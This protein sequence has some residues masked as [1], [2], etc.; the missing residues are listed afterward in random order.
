[1]LQLAA[2]LYEG[3]RNNQVLRHRELVLTPSQQETIVKEVARRRIDLIPRTHTQ[4]ARARRLLSAIGDFCR[5]RTFQFNAPYAP[6]V[7]GVSLSEH[8]ISLLEDKKSPFGKDAEMLLQVL[9]ECVAENLLVPR[10]S[11]ATTGRDAGRIFYLNRTLCVH[12]G[13]PIQH[14]GWQELEI[15]DL[16]EWM[17]RG[18]VPIRRNQ[19]MPK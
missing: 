18:S 5:D 10:P 15:S 14:G 9:S 8:N 17:H 6:G 16:I 12:F 19:L 11:S 13:L 7:T 3:L 1:M 4:G 2:A